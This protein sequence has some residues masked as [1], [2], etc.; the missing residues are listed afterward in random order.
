[1]DIYSYY[2]EKD[3]KYKPKTPNS[4]LLGISKGMLPKESYI[5]L[6][7]FSESPFISNR[8]N[9]ENFEKQFQRI[10][11]L[12]RILA[13]PNKD[14][15]TEILLM[16]TLQEM[17]FSSNS[18][19]ALFASESINGIENS[20][21]NKIY[22]LKTKIDENL[23]YELVGELIE[24]VYRY[25]CIN[26]NRVEIRDFYFDMLLSY[27]DKYRKAGL[28][29]NNRISTLEIEVLIDIEKYTG[30]LEVIKN[31]DASEWDKLYYKVKIEFK[32]K[33][34]KNIIHLL[35]SVDKKKIPYKYRE[36]LSIWVH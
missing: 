18:E 19:I 10:I 20:Y 24:L 32:K 8:L 29:F 22:S 35:S 28:K 21:N 17:V 14:L 25:G 16:N 4:A 6:S 7:L 30:A 2:T 12:E 27:F 3:F 11:D 13:K 26:M 9:S 15:E 23:N 34:F 5:A 33:N 36:S 1:M 31:L